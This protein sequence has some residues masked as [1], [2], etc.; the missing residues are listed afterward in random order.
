[1]IPA[2]PLSPLIHIQEYFCRPRTVVRP[3]S[4]EI[5]IPFTGIIILPRMLPLQSLYLLKNDQV[6]STIN[7]T[8]PVGS[9]HH[10]SY[11][12]MVPQSLVP[13][14]DYKI[15]IYTIPGGDSDDSNTT[16]SIIAAP[17]TSA[18]QSKIGVY[19]NG[20]WYL[21]SNGDGEFNT[22]DSVYSFGLATWSS[23]VGE[24]NPSIPGTKVGVYKDGSW[25]LDYN[26]NGVFDAGD[27]VYGFGLATW[28]PVVG[29]WSGLGKKEIGV[30]K[31]GVWYLDTNGDGS[32][33]AG[34]SVYSF[35]LPGWTSVIG[36]WDADGM[37][38][39]GVYKDGT[40]YLDKNGD[41]AFNTGDSVYS[42]GA[43]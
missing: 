20:A 5:P 38:E 22:G 14:S 16:F 26:G 10:G 2:M 28:S 12:W 17:V 34:D 7:R 32:F 31:D 4:R 37:T 15:R 19:Q 21:D 35:G 23:V 39:I 6:V 27:K 11:D 25:Y 18:N 30:Y 43:S 9:D 8:V 41:G 42:F 1:M 3:G 24:W 40:W 13:G 36:D 29:N 33:N